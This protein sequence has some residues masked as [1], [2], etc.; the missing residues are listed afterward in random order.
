MVTTLFLVDYELAR[1]RYG[2]M[3]NRQDHVFG[4]DGFR[5]AWMPQVSTRRYIILEK[6]QNEDR[7]SK[8][9]HK[10]PKNSNPQSH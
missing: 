3:T 2:L 9:Y 6:Q 1:L 10:N 4:S 7:R 5:Q 8:K